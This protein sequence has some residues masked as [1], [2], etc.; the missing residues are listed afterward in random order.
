MTSSTSS[1]TTEFD[2]KSGDIKIEISVIENMDIFTTLKTQKEKNSQG[3]EKLI[4][5][6]GEKFI[7]EATGFGYVALQ[8][9]IYDQKSNVDIETKHF[10]V[11]IPKVVGLFFF[12]ISYDDFILYF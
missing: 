2:E 3:S 11:K 12:L 10:Y 7:I 8:V 5:R 1:K 6:S 9:K 4:M